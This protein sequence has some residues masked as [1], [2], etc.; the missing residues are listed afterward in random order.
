MTP[1][2]RLLFAV[3]LLAGVATVATA[4]AEIPISA[5]QTIDADRRFLVEMPSPVE[6]ESRTD[7][8]GTRMTDYTHWFAEIDS[9]SL[10]I[11]DYPDDIVGERDSDAE[12]AAELEAVRDALAASLPDGRIVAEASLR[13]NGYPG[14]GF[15]IG[16]GGGR[17]YRSLLFVGPREALVGL[18]VDIDG[19]HQADPSIK[20]FFDSF[21]ILRK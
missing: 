5:W 16:Y 19:E 11:T 20:R 14:L 12:I 18:A 21:A 8:D 17:L 2:A 7:P 6:R 9:F 15:T 13:R 1:L 10:T 4:H 3:V